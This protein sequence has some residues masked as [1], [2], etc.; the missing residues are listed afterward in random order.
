M[1]EERPSHKSEKGPRKA[2]EP[3]GT[4][5][6]PVGDPGQAFTTIAGRDQASSTNKFG[7]RSERILLNGIQRQSGEGRVTRAGRQ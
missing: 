7:P 1:N 6:I 5:T 3:L 4:R 2:Q